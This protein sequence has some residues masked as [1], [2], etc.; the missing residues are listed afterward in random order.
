VN[1]VLKVIGNIANTTSYA[2]TATYNNYTA[3]ANVTV[4]GVPPALFSF[5]T[6]PEKAA[7][8]LVVIRNFTCGY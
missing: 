8:N 7:G 4:N 5:F 1:G 6:L 3:Q 2:I